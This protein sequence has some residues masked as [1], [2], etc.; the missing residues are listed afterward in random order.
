MA[1]IVAARGFAGKFIIRN[2]QFD[3]QV[4][5]VS[6][7]NFAAHTN[8]QGY[9]MNNTG[10][11][12]VSTLCPWLARRKLTSF[13]YEQWRLTAV[14]AQDQLYYLQPA[15]YP[16]LYVGIEGGQEAIGQ[17]VQLTNTMTQWKV[18][19]RDG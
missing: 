11:Q 8:V 7:A 10:A 13:L 16:K 1:H 19:K 18:I 14:N 6:D 12:H 5:D 4:M 2:L 3:Q 9:G 17:N 15:D